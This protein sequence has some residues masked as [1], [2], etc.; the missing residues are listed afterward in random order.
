MLW[1]AF[2]KS[3]FMCKMLR[4][5]VPCKHGIYWRT[6]LNEHDICEKGKILVDEGYRNHHEHGGGSVT[7]RIEFLW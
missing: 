1:L 2:A 7:R 6:A 4:K 5:S 3:H